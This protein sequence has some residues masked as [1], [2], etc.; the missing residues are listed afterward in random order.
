MSYQS[1]GR[2]YARTEDKNQRFWETEHH[3]TS[4]SLEDKILQGHFKVNKNL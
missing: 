1:P 2:P 3:D 4:L